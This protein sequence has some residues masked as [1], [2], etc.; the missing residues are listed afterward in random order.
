MKA[1]PKSLEKKLK[2][3]VSEIN[4][5]KKAQPRLPKKGTAEREIMPAAFIQHIKKRLPRVE[6]WD[7]GPHSKGRPIVVT[8]EE[9]F[10]TVSVPSVSTPA[11]TILNSG[12][13]YPIQPGTATLFPWLSQLAQAFEQYRF[14]RFCIKYYT[15][16]GTTTN[17]ETTIYV[18][19][20]VN[21]PS[22][23]SEVQ[24]ISFDDR[25][26]GPAYCEA[27]RSF[28][29]LPTDL[30]PDGQRKFIRTVSD[31]SDN[32]A[33][34]FDAGNVWSAVEGFAASTAAV[35]GYLT[36][37][38]EI[39]LWKPQVPLVVSSLF[40]ADSD[41][42]DVIPDLANLTTWIKPFM[43][44]QTMFVSNVI[45]YASKDI[46]VFGSGNTMAVTGLRPGS[47]YTLDYGFYNS[48]GSMTGVVSAPG[49]VSSVGCTAVSSIGTASSFGTVAIPWAGHWVFTF[50]ATAAVAIITW[51]PNMSTLAAPGLVSTLRISSNPKTFD[52]SLQPLGSVVPE[53]DLRRV[54]EEL[55]LAFEGFRHGICAGKRAGRFAVTPAQTNL[56]MD[57]LLKD[58]TRSLSSVPLSS[59]PPT[60]QDLITH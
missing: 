46:L 23:T 18:D 19:T 6:G 25:M 59:L 54:S 17:G 22:V 10:D 41:N 43:P 27:T 52:N 14:R 34:T 45:R 12:A 53:I 38:Y 50:L 20:D 5:L 29:V 42:L 55:R 58:Y 15:R 7:G 44:R 56:L 28:H 1:S 11:F 51:A 30:H 2:E 37:E 48:S 16:V 57:L 40:Q 39:E 26:N 47:R 35:W 33:K 49:P 36:V 3:A 4:R 13:G 60:L 21:D 31:P 9:L 8:H 24:A 32:D